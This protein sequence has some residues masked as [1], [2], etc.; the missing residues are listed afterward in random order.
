MGGPDGECLEPLGGGGG[1]Y[2][3]MGA[4]GGMGD[5][6][7]ARPI[8]AYLGLRARPPG[9]DGPGARTGLLLQVVGVV[10]VVV[11]VVVAVAVVVVVVV[12]VVK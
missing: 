2:G 7:G 9:P 12:V 3:H 10:V 1:I 6:G 4:W 5:H 11:V 8:M